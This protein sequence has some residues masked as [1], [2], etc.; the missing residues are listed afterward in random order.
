M[1]LQ[2]YTGV[3]GLVAEWMSRENFDS[4]C[5]NTLRKLGKSVHLDSSS[6]DNKVHVFTLNN[7]NEY[8][9]FMVEVKVVKGSMM[10]YVYNRLSRYDEEL[11]ITLS[12]NVPKHTL[13][14]RVSNHSFSQSQGS[15]IEES[16]GEGSVCLLYARGLDPNTHAVEEGSLSYSS[17]QSIMSYLQIDMVGVSAF[18]SLFLQ[19]LVY[20]PLFK[21]DGGLRRPMPITCMVHYLTQI[22]CRPLV[23]PLSPPQPPLLR[24][25]QMVVRAFTSSS[26]GGLALRN[27]DVYWLRS[28][29]KVLRKTTPPPCPSPSSSSS[30]SP[31]PLPEHIHGL[32]HS[33]PHSLHVVE[34][35][36][37]P[38]HGAPQ[39]VL[40][41]EACLHLPRSLSANPLCTDEHIPVFCAYK[42]VRYVVCDVLALLGCVCGDGGGVQLGDAPDIALLDEAEWHRHVWDRLPAQC[43]QRRLLFRETS[44]WGAAQQDQQQL[45]QQHQQ[46]QSGDAEETNGRRR[47]SRVWGN[48]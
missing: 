23:T 24:D 19:L 30:P 31:P 12:T 4:N 33:V 48:S 10:T 6:S 43:K 25:L 37:F 38:V 45:Q 7:P 13:I 20:Y 17:M 3:E 21:R 46:Q 16:G 26:G 18:A 1:F 36:V 27:Y 11:H 22:L 14:H 47:F 2:R 5:L 42:H 35:C 28:G 40:V 15:S 39:L 34:V 41:V 44:D 32:V 8:Y 29:H 9:N